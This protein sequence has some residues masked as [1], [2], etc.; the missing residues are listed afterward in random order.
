M[1]PDERWLSAEPGA[2]AGTTK[3]RPAPD[4][5]PASAGG[6]P[7][8]DARTGGT[9]D[10]GTREAG[11]GEAGTREAGVTREAEAIRRVQAARADGTGGPD[12]G[13]PA[14]STRHDGVPWLIALGVFAAYTTLSVFRL[15]QLDP[16]SWDLG[17]F[18][19]YV[20]QYAHLQAPIVDIKGA[21]FNLLG[22]HFHP[23]VALI[24]PIF[25]LV[26][27]PVTLL[28]A[29]AALVAVSVIPVSRAAAARL[30]TGAGRAIG[31]AYGL[32]W[33]LQQ[34][35]ENDFHEIAFAVPLL[36]CSLSALICGRRRA[37]AL[38]A[39]PLVFVKEDQGLTVAAIGV[40]M[41][42]LARR[43]ARTAGSTAGNTAGH[44]AGTYA[45]G[46]GT[47]GAGAGTNGADT[48][49]D[50]AVAGPDG[51]VA[52]LDG[53]AAGDAAG[54]AAGPRG[55]D[56]WGALLIAWGLGWSYL[57]VAVIIPHF[58]PA[59]QYPY[60]N[61]GGAVSAGGHFALGPLAA[62]LLAAS[63]VKLPTLV[64]ILLVTAF[65]AVRSPVVLV[66]IPSLALRFISTDSAYWGTAWHYNATVMP[67]VF[68]AAI[69]GLARIRAA[70]MRG[71]A[72][73]LGLAMERHGAAIM[74]AVCAAL[75]FQ[76]PLSNL[77]NPQTYAISDQVKAADAAMARVPDGVT[78]ET[79]LDLLAPLAARTDTFW[80]GNS[81]NPPP[82][83]I[84][85]DS[86]STDWQPPPANI[87]AFIDQR[88]PGVSYRETFSDDGVYVF[89]RVSPPGGWR[90]VAVRS[91]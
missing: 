74:L 51:A 10:A 8:P 82:Q 60:W 43:A 88:H 2:A 83:Y 70:R 89:R 11:T 79:D 46:A 7:V 26:P 25:R 81:G 17:I 58:N 47:D 85:F 49:A 67:I 9:W 57:A 55:R 62:Q 84:V 4:A 75:A 80:L 91:G 63:S 87:P 36:A 65:L 5:A 31:A 20:K 42:L 64:M 22:D 41:I 35:V 12:A 29:Q 73:P 1:Q 16:A 56:H 40:I 66:A 54:R 14:G 30:G 38:W 53:A 48:D 72:G 52:G 15:W 33:G 34:L 50:G 44:D 27:T 21:G 24:A 32:S 78:V 39:L 18:T 45:A 6:P 68:V 28:V 19:E 90:R 37:A 23:I 86:H 61:M 59:H 77:W 71:T 69:D 13:R 76:F 3:S